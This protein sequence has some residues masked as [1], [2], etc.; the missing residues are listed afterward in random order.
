MEW[1]SENLRHLLYN[2]ISM[3]PLTKSVLN[4]GIPKAYTKN[5]MSFTH[6][7]GVKYSFINQTFQPNYN[8]LSLSQGDG[9]TDAIGAVMGIWW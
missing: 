7:W 3:P 9:R 8:V 6:S 5:M 4:K 1:I 2:L